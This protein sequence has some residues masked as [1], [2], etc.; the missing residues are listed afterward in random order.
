[1]IKDRVKSPDPGEQAAAGKAPYLVEPL[2]DP[3]AIRPLLGQQRAFAAYALAHL[4]PRLFPRSRWWRAAGVDGE[5]LVMHARTGLGP[6]LVALGAPPALEAIL[7][8]HPGAFYTFAMFQLEHV[9]VAQRH[10]TLSRRGVSLRLSVSRESFQPVEGAARRLHGRDL[11][12]V[13]ALQRSEGFGFHSA[14]ALDDG[15][16]YG[17]YRA[18][19]LVAM[20]GTHVVAPEMGVAIVGN[21]V[22]HPRC[23][24]QG[25][26][27]VA[28]S[29]VTAALLETCPFVLLTVEETNEPALHVYQRLGYQQ[30]CRLL[31]SGARRKDTFG[32]ASLV[33][34]WRAR[35]RGG[36]GQEVVLIG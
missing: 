5:A 21:V 22:T 31:E 24:G 20:A 17:V 8:L 28:T 35:R 11:A 36:P 29:A 15:V 30:E 18:D 2:T 19:R 32:L 7:R 6:S 3:E 9:A 4:E 26:G 1:M 33:R 12:D 23:R 13:D 10:F 34:R 27:T 25:Y 16:Y 14:A